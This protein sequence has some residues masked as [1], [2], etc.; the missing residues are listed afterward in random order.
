MERYK[1]QR[2]LEEPDRPV[3]GPCHLLFVINFENLVTLLNEITS[4][5][6]NYRAHWTATVPLW[7][8]AALYTVLRSKPARKKSAVDYTSYQPSQPN[9]SDPERFI[10]VRF[11]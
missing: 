5:T 4:M 8:H 7:S 10:S 6:T 9:Q 2:P 11:R 1:A 3:K